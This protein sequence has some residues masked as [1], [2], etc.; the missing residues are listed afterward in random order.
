M[1]V[2][3]TPDFTR[4]PGVF[5][6]GSKF[7]SSEFEF[8]KTRQKRYRWNGSTAFGHR[9]EEKLIKRIIPSADKGMCAPLPAEGI[10]P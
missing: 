2:S 10:A 1:S 6:E 7:D 8:K 4:V 3:G 9:Y 5:L